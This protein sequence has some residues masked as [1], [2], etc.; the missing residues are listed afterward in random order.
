MLTS[1]LS[2]TME[3]FKAIAKRVELSEEK[4]NIR[5]PSMAKYVTLRQPSCRGS[6]VQITSHHH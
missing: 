3:T 2:S 4:T 1:Q 5:L 6:Q